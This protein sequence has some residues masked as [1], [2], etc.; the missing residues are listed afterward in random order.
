MQV[1]YGHQSVPAW[2]GAAIAIGNFDGVHLGHR[3]LI[4]RARELA[5]ANDSLAVALTFDPHPSSVVGKGCPPMLS[6]IERRIE[7]LGEAGADAVVVEPFTMG[8]ANLA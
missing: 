3:A 1:V 4:A 5:D 2:R 6:S 7:L 8:L